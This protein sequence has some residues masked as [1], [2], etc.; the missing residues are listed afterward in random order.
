MAIQAKGKNADK[1]SEIPFKGWKEIFLRVK[2]QVADDHVQIVSA[3]VAFYFFLSLFPTLSA[4]V[5]IYGLV[6]EPSGVEQQMERLLGT[7]PTQAH[8]LVSGILKDIVGKSDGTLGWSL[9]IGLLLSLWSANN[10]MKALFEGINIAYDEKDE[11]GF[12][13]KTAI[14]LGVTLVGILL[15]F[16][17]LSMVIGF[18]AF[19]KEMDIP[20]SLKAMIGWL[21]WPILAV[22]LS[23]LLGLLYKIAPA[24]DNPKFR[25]ITWGAGIASVL[26]ILGSLLFTIYIDNFANYDKTY[27]SL[28]AV[29]VMLL[30]LFLTSFVVLLGAEINSEM[31]HQT[32]KD[33]TIGADKPMGK[34]G[35][36][37]ADHVAEGK[38]DKG[39]KGEE[40]SL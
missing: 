3:G 21:R 36:Y 8:E 18:P 1:P 10:G 13:K 38:D 35:A 15:G 40:T 29:I 5:S 19:V 24:R 39:R 25:W 12:F 37:H 33:T 11:R 7:L 27:G 14:T 2:D 20:N 16:F 9:V 6:M 17:S 23:G 34:R 30:W 26:W 31:E 22:M 32:R 4:L 28:A